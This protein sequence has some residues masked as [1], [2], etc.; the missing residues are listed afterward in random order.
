MTISLRPFMPRLVILMFALS[1]AV[2]LAAPP[3]LAE[4]RYQRGP[5]SAAEA[6]P[7]PEWQVSE[8]IRGPA[9]SLAALEGQ[10]V[11]I[12]FFQLWCPGC[13]RFSIPL[14]SYWEEHFAK[15]IAAE[16]LALISI[17]TVF[18]GHDY[19]TPERLRAFVEEK[20][21]RH[22][23]AVDR[24]S[25]GKRLPDS[26]IL[27]GTHGTPEMAIIDKAGRRSASRSSA[28]SIPTGQRPSSA[29]FWPRRARTFRCRR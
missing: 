24:Q 4:T 2:V 14:M 7:A 27:F 21:M 25:A 10:V 15:E 8:W 20:K 3:G 26:M 28:P 9:T 18:E 19:Q 17:H 16:E 1:T 12:D 22:P 6:P 23:V 29:R 13:K 5:F 11:V